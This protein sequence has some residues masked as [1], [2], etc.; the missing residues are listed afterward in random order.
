ML[1]FTY[2]QVMP[3]F[4]DFVFG[5]GEQQYAQ[6]FHF[7]GFIQDNRLH[8]FEKSL[9][10]PEIGW[11]GREVRLCYSLMSVEPSDGQQYWPWSIRTTAVHHVFDI[12]TGRTV[13]I[14]IKGDE[15]IK[16]RIKSATGPRGI[17]EL[18]SFQTIEHSFSS[19]LAAHL[20]LCDWSIEH[21]YRYITFLEKEFQETSRRS[22]SMLAGQNVREPFRAENNHS[23]IPGYTY[24]PLSAKSLESQSRMKQSSSHAA[25]VE[26]P[27]RPPMAAGPHMLYNQ[28]GD[29]G[30]QVF[31]FTD[32]QR[33]QF[34][35]EK[36]NET[37]LILKADKSILTEI[38]CHYRNTTELEDWPCHLKLGCK[39]EL[40]HF[41][42]RMVSVENSFTLQQS[43][44][45]T[46]LRLLANRKS[47]VMARLANSAHA[48]ADNKQLFGMLEY[49]SLEASKELAKE[50][51]QSAR[52][53]ETLALDMHEIAQKTKEETISM[54]IV[55]F[56]TLFFLPGT[57]VSVSRL[58]RFI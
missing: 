32:L 55:T 44:A 28:D 48:K 14:I 17:P 13:W 49:Q 31:N 18:S 2:H 34:L 22:L 24:G 25:R 6:G 35:E 37:L 50:A 42:R 30:H 43:R 46:L 7:N 20:L 39:R 15:A 10:I 56:V 52:R 9:N 5:F 54:R 21:W 51:S 57:F 8:G 11:S 40:L 3:G 33:I 23:I 29:P 4:L 36:A 1:L 53:A 38:E 58:P 26:P 41:E 45:E 16:S 27:V 47:L 19:A 12:E